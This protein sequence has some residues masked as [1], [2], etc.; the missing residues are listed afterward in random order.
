MKIG[1]LDEPRKNIL[2]TL[3]FDPDKALINLNGYPALKINRKMHYVHI[4][5]AEHILGI[6]PERYKAEIH[7][8]DE[9]R[10]NF[11]PSNLELLTVKQHRNQHKK[12][13]TSNPFFG[14]RHT[15]E[16]KLKIAEIAR[17]Y[18]NTWERSDDGTFK[19]GGFNARAS[20][21]L[22]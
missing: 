1:D 16:T 22:Q 3:G 11:L 7:H 19:A 17:G 13:G 12:F 4:I 15:D 5:V 14:H 10:W 9:N 6:R 8:I 2:V 21:S 18:A 20:M